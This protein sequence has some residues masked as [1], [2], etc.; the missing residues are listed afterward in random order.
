MKK[1]KKMKK[2][3]KLFGNF[4]HVI[5][6]FHQLQDK[7]HLLQQGKYNVEGELDDN[8]YKRHDMAFFFF[9]FFF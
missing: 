8:Q 4:L 1:K 6:L 9:F 2:I 5:S 7:F 3:P